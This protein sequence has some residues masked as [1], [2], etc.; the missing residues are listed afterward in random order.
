MPEATGIVHHGKNPM[1]NAIVFNLASGKWTT[2]NDYGYFRINSSLGDT[3]RV[4]HY[5]YEVV[6]LPVS[7]SPLTI[8]LKENP[9]PMEAI[10]VYKIAPI[11]FEQV[12]VEPNQGIN[13]SMYSFPNLSIRTYGG[14]AGVKNI[15][16]ESGLSSH[17]KIL[18][19][20]I[21]MTS[22]Q[23][24]ET[25]ISQLPHF[26]FD[27]ITV[28]KRSAISFGSG[29]IDG[30]IQI[31][32]PSSTKIEATAGSFG[33]KSMSGILG[34]NRNKWH[35]NFGLGQANYKGDY[36]YNYNGKTGKIINNDFNQ[37]FY[38][39]DVKG[40][41][42]SNLFILM[43]FLFSDQERGVSGLV[44][45]PSPYAKRKDQIQ[46]FQ[47][48]IF[49]QMNKHLFSVSTQTR[50]SNETYNDSQ[51]VIDSKHDLFVNQLFVEWHFKPK[52]NI[53][54][55]QGIQLKSQK[56]K[57]TDTNHHLHKF[58]AY[59]NTIN[60][61]SRSNLSF[62]T[63]FRYDLQREGLSAWTWQ[64]GIE[65][66]KN[67]YRLSI[68][69]GNGFRF[70][71]FNDMYWIPGGNSKLKPETSQWMKLENKFNLNDHSLTFK[72]TLKLNTN[73]I[74]WKSNGS[75]WSPEN[76]ARSRKQVLTLTASGPL[77]G[78]ISY[79]GHFTLNDAKDTSLKKQLR[80]TPNTLGNLSFYFKNPSID[81]WLSGHYMGE[82][83]SMYSWP[84]D[85]MLNPYFILSAGLNRPLSNQISISIICENLLDTPLMT[86]N[87]YPESERSFSI[88]IQFKPN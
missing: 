31:T 72:T 23:N 20:G 34:I 8:D 37:L 16:L 5:G 86:I 78:S 61:Q 28:S 36:N 75:F 71:T 19:N 6:T 35:S 57:S 82:R 66:K 38:T 62:E 27:N 48:K 49:W 18:W 63:G 42:S 33:Y 67:I 13:I 17:T 50:K 29:S 70:P 15:T 41:V 76:I 54:F 43:N 11:Q 81:W 60:W 77:I 1:P 83:I 14:Y 9:I 4:M 45:S 79:S 26:L 12:S 7:S 85:V 80:Y 39:M 55:E 46:L 51:Y 47:L 73:L 30:T 84:T 52:S 68:I 24:G 65:Y 2:T 87:G 32:G 25:D 56:I 69:A 10:N 59:N 40:R 74:Q 88:K 44:Y 53:N 3:L 21:D 58:W 22:P 64:S